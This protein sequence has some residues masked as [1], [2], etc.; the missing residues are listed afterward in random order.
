MLRSALLVPSLVTAALLAAAPTAAAPTANP[1]DRFAAISFGLAANN[2]LDAGLE[3]SSEGIYLKISRRGRVA[4]YKVQ[5]KST[6]AGLKARFGKLGLIDVTFRPTKTRVEKPPKG[7]KGRPSTDSEGIFVGTIQFTGEFEYVQI[8]ATEAKGTMW[9]NREYEWKCPRRKE[10]PR[11]HVTQRPSTLGFRDRSDP[12]KEPAT[13][14]VLSRR[15]DCFFAAYATPNRR[16]RGR[17]TFV[18]AKFES[19]DGMEIN[20]G[21]I[22]DADPSAFVFNHAAGTAQVHPPHPFSGSG[23]FKRRPNARNLWRSTIQVPLLGANP[24]SVGDPGFQAR[25]VHALPGGE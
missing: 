8:E 23:I 11:T 18:G 5:G 4:S 10:P 20:R 19:V 9:V 25:L 12:D 13:L 3:T 14:A 1:E 2:G 16:G 21:T 15:C 22:V 6:E 24:L 7:C 17:T